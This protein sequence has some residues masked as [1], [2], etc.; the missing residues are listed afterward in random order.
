[1]VV[2][3]KSN[4]ALEEGGSGST[5]CCSHFVW[6]SNVE[7]PIQHGDSPGHRWPW[8]YS[9]SGLSRVWVRSVLW[10]TFAQ[11]NRRTWLFAAHFPPTV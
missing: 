8:F 5:G 9:V 2:S 10:P 7:H 4:K 11:Q 3:M 6:K 1:L